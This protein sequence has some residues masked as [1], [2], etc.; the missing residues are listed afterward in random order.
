VTPVS[1]ILN[2][3]IVFKDE[4]DAEIERYDI[5]NVKRLY[6]WEVKITAGGAHFLHFYTRF[7]GEDWEIPGGRENIKKLGG[8]RWAIHYKRDMLQ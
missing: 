2:R 3:Y 6:L 7:R 8:L 5:T 4:D 1:N